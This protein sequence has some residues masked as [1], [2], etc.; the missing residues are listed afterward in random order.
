MQPWHSQSGQ[1]RNKLSLDK[2]SCILQSSAIYI[3]SI[4]TGSLWSKIFVRLNMWNSTYINQHFPHLGCIW[5]WL[6]RT[7]MAHGHRINTSLSCHALSSTFSIQ[8]FYL[9]ATLCIILPQNSKLKRPLFQSKLLLSTTTY[10]H[11]TW[12]VTTHSSKPG[13]AS[14]ILHLVTQFL[15]LHWV[16]CCW[17]VCCRFCC[18][19]VVVSGGEYSPF[20]SLHADI[21]RL[22]LWCLCTLHLLA[23]QVTI[24]NSG[25]CCCICATSFQN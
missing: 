20:C 9:D 13:P 17:L 5:Q 12:T 23:C 14:I 7:I 21:L 16:F 25:L 3:Y 10:T 15:L 1:L 24:G 4:F 6:D 18:L 11:I 22:Y 2:L 8:H 19:F